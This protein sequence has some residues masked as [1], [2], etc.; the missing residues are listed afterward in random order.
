[1]LGETLHRIAGLLFWA[2]VGI[3]VLT[4]LPS[5]RLGLDHAPAAGRNMAEAQR[6]R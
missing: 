2:A 5:N 1:M 6:Y 3:V 4:L